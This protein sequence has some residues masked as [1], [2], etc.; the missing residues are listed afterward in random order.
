MS[1][2]T[3]TLTA[4]DYAVLEGLLGN[5]R[6]AFAGAAMLIRRKLHAAVPVFADDIAS[7]VAT[8]NSRI[9]YRINAG[10]V[11]ERTIVAAAH[12]SILGITLQLNSPRGLA[13]VGLSAGQSIASTREDGAEEVL[14]LDAVLY[15][16]EAERRIDPVA[17]IIADA[18]PASAPPNA[19]SHLSAFRLRRAGRSL[20]QDRSH[21]HGHDN[22]DDPGPSAA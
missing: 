9:R 19:V 14:T 5:P 13:L 17:A 22:G 2:P 8:I 6:E 3:I 18:M 1:T 20:G 15:Q 10:R 4:K 12:E 21:D 16:P 11:E 7:D